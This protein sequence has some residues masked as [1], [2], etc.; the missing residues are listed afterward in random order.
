M[1]GEE[2]ESVHFPAHFQT[3]NISEKKRWQFNVDK[4]SLNH[5]PN[6]ALDLPFN[7]YS[8]HVNHNLMFSNTENCQKKTQKSPIRYGLT[9]CNLMT[10]PEKI[11]FH[12]VPF[13]LLQKNF[14][15][16]HNWLKKVY[17]IFTTSDFLRE[18]RYHL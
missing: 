13:I 6:S 14:P 18:K 17:Y 2:A 9:N 8:N 1:V 15:L 3:R 7:I 5:L 12:F 4:I 10:V 11:I 16:C